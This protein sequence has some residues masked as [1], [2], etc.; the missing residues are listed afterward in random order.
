MVFDGSLQ[1]ICRALC[2]QHGEEPGPLRNP[3]AWGGRWMFAGV[4]EQCK[5]SLGHTGQRGAFLSK[6]KA[7]HLSE[8]SLGQR[9]GQV[10]GAGNSTSTLGWNRASRVN[11]GKRNWRGGRWPDCEG[12]KCP[13]GFQRGLYR[14]QWRGGRCL[15][16]G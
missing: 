14:G 3:R 4:R 7:G 12:L 2:W 1:S 5:G 9:T 10:L 11:C 15:G 13:P 6:E 16:P 8:N